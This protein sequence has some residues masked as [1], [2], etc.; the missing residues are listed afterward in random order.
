MA[1]AAL[2]EGHATT[3]RHSVR[4][5]QQEEEWEAQRGRKTQLNQL[6]FRRATTTIWGIVIWS[7]EG[8]TA[9]FKGLAQAHAQPWYLLNP[10]LHCQNKTAQIYVSEKAN[11]RYMQRYHCTY[12]TMYG[13]ARVLQE[14]HE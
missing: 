12:G 13:L 5:A 8:Q 1:A 2:D 3:S 6:I 14:T 4:A 10:T 9:P 11:R 7:S